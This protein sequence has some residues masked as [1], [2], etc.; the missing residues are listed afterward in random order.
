[1]SDNLKEKYLFFYLKT[2]GGHLAPA[3]SVSQYLNA[4]KNNVEVELVDGFEN[5][6]NWLKA[7][8][9][10]GYRNLQS[11]AQLI[12]EIIYAF[13]KIP[14]FSNLTCS[15]I[16]FYSITSIERII[17]SRKPQKVVIFHF[18]LLKPVRKIIQKHKLDCKIITVVTDP[19]TPHPIWFLIKNQNFIVFSEELKTKIVKRRI[20]PQSISVFPFILD[21]KF[22]KPA[23]SEEINK[24]K[25]NLGFEEKRKIILIIG[26]AD[27]LVKAD[28]IIKKMVQKMNQHYI[29]I[30]CGKNEEL[31]NKAEKIKGQTGY[32]FLKVY[33]LIDFVPDMLN[34]SDVVITKCGASTFMEILLSKKVP[35]V[36]NYLWEQE[37]GNMEY[38]R[39]NGLGIY[40]TNIEKISEVVCR[41]ISD[42]KYYAEFINRIENQKLRNGTEEVSEYIYNF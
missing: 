3:R 7:I 21:E 38:L 29:V 37:K 22:G 25:Q 17:L 28:Q 1:M 27:G 13:N 41:F 2:G 14:L 18:F 26:G 11:K 35:V 10:D 33:K 20:A 24:I 6:G 12:Y 30:V 15:I 34:I 16:S 5:V 39:D 19:Y 4:K 23:S 8:I 32:Q 42:E 36:T 40:E 31:Y 9:E